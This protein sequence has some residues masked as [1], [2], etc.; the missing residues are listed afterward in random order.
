MSPV[1]GVREPHPHRLLPLSSGPPASQGSVVTHTPALW[2]EDD[3][4][5]AHNA[6][7]PR[8]SRGAAGS[9]PLH[10]AGLIP[11]SSPG[12]GKELQGDHC[13][14]PVWPRGGKC[15]GQAHTAQQRLLKGT[16]DPGRLGGT[17]DLNPTGS[18]PS[19]MKTSTFSIESIN[20]TKNRKIKKQRYN[21]E[22]LSK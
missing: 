11:N 13:Q 17:C 12:F 15:P 1:G 8:G 20:K 22:S 9:A 19:K 5:E 14:G 18:M 4:E 3:K 10:G 7:R 6:G 2:K 16:P 21:L